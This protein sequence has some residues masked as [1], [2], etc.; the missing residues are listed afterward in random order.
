MSGGTAGVHDTLRDTLMVKVG[1]FFPQDEVFQQS[2]SAGSRA[3]GI[4]I[5]SDA[6]PL[7]GGQRIAFSAFAVW[8]E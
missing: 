4:L 3:Q 8:L 7:I 6:H 2:R 5:V 1:D